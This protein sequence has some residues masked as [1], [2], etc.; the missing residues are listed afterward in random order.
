MIFPLFWG[1]IE[2]SLLPKKERIIFLFL[3]AENSELSTTIEK[4]RNEQDR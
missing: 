4:N 2:Q 1:F 3:P